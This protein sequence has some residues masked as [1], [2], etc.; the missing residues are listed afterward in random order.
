MALR[1]TKLDNRLLRG[2]RVG[3][4]VTEHSITVECLS[5]GDL[6]WSINIMVDGKRIHR[7]V[8]RASDGVKRGT[9]ERLIEKLRTDARADRLSLPQ[10]R[11]L[12]R[13]FAQ[14]AEDYIER[15]ESSGG[16]D[17]KNK[18]RHLRQR[19]VPYLGRDRLDKITGYR[20]GQYRQHRI[21]EGASEATINR[22]MSTLSH[23]LNRAASKDWGWMKKDDLPEIPKEKEA[24]KQI[25]ILTVAQR[26]RLLK[27]A[28]ED[29]D[30]RAWL[31]V[32]FGLNASMRHS[33]IVQRRYD[34]VDLENCFIWINK[35][36]A[37]ERQQPITPALR[38]ALARQRKM[39]ADPNG[40]I[41][42]A[43][44]QTCK[45]P[46][47]PDMREPFARIVKRA[48]LDP[49]LCT[50]HIMRHT[51]I[52]ALVMAKTDVPTIQK[53][54]GHKTPSQVLHYVHLFGEH[55]HDALGALNI[56]MPEQVTQELHTSAE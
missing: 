51:S 5:S 14:A 3:D 47:R 41:F 8:G 10:G 38:D 11:K 9:A 16:K 15:M 13:S 33:E 1:F 27:A 48:S 23:L 28:A 30:S 35:A 18:R 52:S 6:R 53:I 56:A 29:Q 32:M 19:L 50:P 20:L 2:L 21:N 45:T 22:E 37:G 40:W 43:A 49:K 39:E 12:H 42:P 17:M 55:V 7:V 26:Q 44:R 34:E 31:F 25:R 46:H 24:R 54:S 36:K 4:R